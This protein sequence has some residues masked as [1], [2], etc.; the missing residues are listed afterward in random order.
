MQK[1]EP[2]ERLRMH[3][4]HVVY[5]LITYVTLITYATALPY[6]AMQYYDVNYS[7]FTNLQSPSRRNC[8][9]L[10][11]KWNLFLANE[12]NNFIQWGHMNVNGIPFIQIDYFAWS[13]SKCPVS[14]LIMT[15][16]NQKTK[17][18][19][20]R[21]KVPVATYLIYVMEL[22]ITMCHNFIIFSPVRME[23][24]AH[25]CD[26]LRVSWVTS[27]HNLPTDCPWVLQVSMTE[28]ATHTWHAIDC[29]RIHK[30]SIRHH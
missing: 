5:S 19:I 30:F 4:R 29:F 11:P 26:W 17:K 2:V 6:R 15:R 10:F 14:E 3:R 16:W 13:V 7:I 27:C 18:T 22:K 25:L 12:L 8:S 20:T 28:G 9:R 21:K 23:Q 24:N 1:N